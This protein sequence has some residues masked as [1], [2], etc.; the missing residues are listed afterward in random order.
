M[1]PQPMIPQPKQFRYHVDTR[2][3]NSGDANNLVTRQ[4]G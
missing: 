3:T 1:I 4:S 2:H